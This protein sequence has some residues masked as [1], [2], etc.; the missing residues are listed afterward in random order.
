MDKQVGNRTNAALPRAA[1][2]ERTGKENGG[3]RV[4]LGDGRAFLGGNLGIGQAE[5][6][7]RAILVGALSEVAG[8]VRSKGLWL[9]LLLLLLLQLVLLVQTFLDAGR[10]EAADNG[11]AADR[12]R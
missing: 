8:V 10:E 6:L 9:L 1:H 11:I 2:S 3:V 4:Q 5:P 7:G 12:C